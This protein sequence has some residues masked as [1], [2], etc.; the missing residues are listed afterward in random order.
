MKKIVGENI[1]LFIYLWQIIG[2]EE[3]MD[4]VVVVVW[5]DKIEEWTKGVSEW[6]R[7]WVGQN[8]HLC[9]QRV[10]N[11]VFLQQHCGSYYKMVSTQKKIKIK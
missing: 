1:Y 9:G 4:V 3:A 2:C 11:I 5:E 8:Q 10:D 6:V 7:E